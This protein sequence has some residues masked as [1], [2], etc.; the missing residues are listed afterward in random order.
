MIRFWFVTLA[1]AL[2]TFAVVA[3]AVAKPSVSGGI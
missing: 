1:L 3:D 2:M